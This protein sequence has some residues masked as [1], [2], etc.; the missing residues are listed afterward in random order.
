MF[1]DEVAPLAGALFG[2][3]DAGHHGH[4]V[5]WVLQVVGHHRQQVVAR[6]HR[7]RGLLVQAGVVDGLG[8]PA[9]QLLREQDLGLAVPPAGL[10]VDQ[11]EPAQRLAACLE[12]HHDR[13]ARAQLAEQAQVFGVL[14]AGLD[15]LVV[16]VP[17]EQGAPGA[18]GF[19][20]RAV[21]VAV[22]RVPLAQLPGQGHLVGSWCASAANTKRSPSSTSTAHQ[23]ASRGTARA[24]SRSSVCRSSSVRDKR[25]PG[26]RQE[27]Q[28]LLRRPEIFGRA[29]LL[30]DVARG[31]HA[32]RWL[33]VRVAERHGGTLQDTSEPSGRRTIQRAFSTRSP[34]RARWR[35]VSS[36]GSGRPSVPSRPYAFAHSL[37]ST[38]WSGTP[39]WRAASGLKTRMTPS[40][41]ATMTPGADLLD[42]RRG[43]AAL[44]PVR[45]L[46]LGHGQLQAGGRSHTPAQLE[47]RLHLAAQHAQGLELPRRQVAR[48]RVDHAQRPQ[49]RAL[50]AHERHARVEADVRRARDQRVRCEARVRGR[51]GHHHHV[52]SPRS[53]ARR[54]TRR[55]ASRSPRPPRG[56]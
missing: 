22:R 44:G 26:L 20:E 28:A 46:G 29:A 38:A 14:G 52:R 21:A 17:V 16:D 12:R 30:G 5:Q 45:A 11:R 42:H 37:A 25:K 27:A 34:R 1:A 13:G 36:T 39:C 10:R 2:L 53:R 7:P 54:T 51:V 18:H 15:H 49:P 55:G 19:G 33:A 6:P 35:G 31:E 43:P 24:A 32:A 50:R 56:T 3:Q 41:S 48:P 40:A 4:D 8:G 9:P 47:L 23:S